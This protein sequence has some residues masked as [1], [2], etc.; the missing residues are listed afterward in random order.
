LDKKHITRLGFKAQSF[1]TNTKTLKFKTNIETKTEL[2][3]TPSLH[4]TA[5]M[6]TVTGK[7]VKSFLSY[8]YNKNKNLKSQVYENNTDPKM[9]EYDTTNAL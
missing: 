5:V 2:S 7:K 9:L 8:K 4:I 6:V 1:K 3:R